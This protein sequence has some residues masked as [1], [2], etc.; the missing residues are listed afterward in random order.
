MEKRMITIMGITAVAFIAAVPI[1][2]LFV[3][4]SAQSIYDDLESD[5]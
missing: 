4:M 5:S 3:I 2:S 1:A